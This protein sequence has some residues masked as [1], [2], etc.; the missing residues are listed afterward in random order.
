MKNMAELIIFRKKMLSRIHFLKYTT[1][2]LNPTH[3]ILVLIALSS[4]ACTNLKT[5]QRLH[6]HITSI[7][8]TC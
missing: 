4:N 5:R 7:F 3:E 1:H 8:L 2:M 6:M